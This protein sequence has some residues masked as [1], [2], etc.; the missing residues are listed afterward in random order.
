MLALA[1][2]LSAGQTAS[3]QQQRVLIEKFT[4]AW[5]Q[6]CPMGA[7]YMQQ[8]M[9]QNPE[10]AIG[11]AIHNRDGMEIPEEAILAPVYCGGYPTGAVNRQYPKSSPSQWA[12]LIPGMTRNPAT[13]DV[14][15]KSVNYNSITKQFTAEVQ[16]QF[17]ADMSGDVRF[18]LYIVEDSV[19]GSGTGYDQVNAFN[20]QQGNPFY[21]KGN[22]MKGYF[23]RHVVRKMMGGAWG[24]AGSLPLSIKSG[25]V[26]T[27]T[28]TQ[29]VGAWKPDRITLIGIVQKYDGQNT[30]NRQIL[31]VVEEHLT[32]RSV[33]P[34]LS[35]A[36]SPYL[37]AGL[38]ATK[39]QNIAIKN[40]HTAPITVDIELDETNSAYPGDWTVTVT[41]ATATIPAGGTATAKI[42]F[43]LP[44]ETNP[45]LAN[46]M[47]KVTPRA[48]SGMLPKSN[49]TAVF[50]LSENGKYAYI[51]GL[52]PMFSQIDKYSVALQNDP[53]FYK[54]MIELQ[55]NEQVIAAYA[56]NFTAIVLPIHGGFFSA[57]DYQNQ[58]VGLPI[59]ASPGVNYPNF[60]KMITDWLA[61]GKRVLVS[62]PRSLWWAL[63]QT[64]ASA[65]GKN[66]DAISFLTST[67]G[68]ELVK[69]E[70]RFTETQNGNQIQ[71]GFTKFNVRGVPG[72]AVGDQ[73]AG[74]GN[75]NAN[76]G[77]SFW[78]DV[79]RLRNGSKS[80]PCFF[81]DNKTDNIVGV[82]YESGNAKLVYLTFGMEALNGAGMNEF[83]GKITNYLVGDLKPKTPEISSTSGRLD[84]GSIEV[85]QTKD[86]TVDVMNIGGAPLTVSKIEVMGT[87]DKNFTIAA[88]N[89]GLPLTLQPAEKR[90]VTVKFAPTAEKDYLAS[91]VVTSNSGNV[92][93]SAMTIDL[94]G[95]GM[96]TAPVKS[97]LSASSE[98]LSFGQVS[99]T[100]ELAVPLTNTGTK[101]ITLKSI[102]FTGTDKGKFAVK[103]FKANT[104]LG[105]A[106]ANKTLKGMTVV[107]TPGEAGLFTAKMVVKSEIEGGTADEFTMDVTGEGIASGVNEDGSVSGAILTARATPN[108]ASAASMLAYTVSGKAPQTVSIAVVDMTGREALNLGTFTADPGDYATTLDATVLPAGAYHVV[109][110]CAAETITL[111]FTVVR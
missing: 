25:D 88:G 85:N 97:V 53:D 81:A 102:E 42:S 13:V 90:T 3:A 55:F 78:T 50:C 71:V 68:I 70:P 105:T 41:P 20:T 19:T 26:K 18:N 51:K 27:F 45:A 72:D 75:D 23:H 28:Y 100:K 93:N 66:S 30:A 109:V 24:T 86:M 9:D 46:A 106:A 44:A 14:S 80:V 89:T 5:C 34:A 104:L 40:T 4:G 21:G 15:F 52:V 22:P 43:Q 2:F 48:A 33:R 92:D 60:A 98:N 108:P 87:D 56:S 62:A 101:E 63:D 8:A 32:I 54:G 83:M 76:V 1:A 16:A 59:G 6:Y 39:E 74:L 69:S 58:K 96:V 36:P 29:S 103:G 79:M 94:R 7:Y 61:A 47:V 111:P 67:L 35:V 73:L 38:G 82:H 95:K 84:Y 11:V 107:F 49:S 77:H 37:T 31:N 64:T 10:T 17:F 57:N 91:L 99:G 65:Q 110:R 12:Q